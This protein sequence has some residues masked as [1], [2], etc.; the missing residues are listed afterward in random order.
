VNESRATNRWLLAIASIALAILPPVLH[1]AG[2]TAYLGGESSNSSAV[3]AKGVRHSSKKYGRN[4]PPWFHDRVK[5]LA[6]DYPFRDRA[7]R[8]EGQ[9]IFRLTLDLKTGEV[10]RVTMLKST[11]FATLDRSTIAAFRRWLWKPGKW[12]EIEMPITFTMSPPPA[13]LPPGAVRIPS[14]GQ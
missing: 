7:R 11:G 1:G 8:N 3:D 12:K 13:R 4:L 6:P 10:I 2:S 9:G 5:A 14:L